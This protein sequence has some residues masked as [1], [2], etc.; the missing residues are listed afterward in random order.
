MNWSHEEKKQSTETGPQKTQILE[1]EDRDFRITMVN[2]SKELQEKVGITGEKIRK[3]TEI[4]KLTK[5][6]KQILELKKK[7]SEILKFTGCD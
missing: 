7:I 3:S 1:L 4:W 5:N 2:L 6:Q